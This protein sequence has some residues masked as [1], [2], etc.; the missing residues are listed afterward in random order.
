[1][2]EKA[3]TAEAQKH[4]TKGVF[5]SAHQIWLAGLGAFFKAEE[6]GGKL[7]ESLVKEGEAIESRRRQEME[8]R[9]EDMHDKATEAWDQLEQ[10]FQDRVSRSIGRMGL[11]TREDIEE[12]HKAVEDLNQRVAALTQAA[13]GRA[14]SRKSGKAEEGA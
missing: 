5:G 10:M 8:K 11:A 9:T 6:E 13:K 4:L 2:T 7:F 3:K 14:R 12:L 1:M